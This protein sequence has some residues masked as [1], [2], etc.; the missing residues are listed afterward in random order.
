MAPAV[1]PCIPGIPELRRRQVPRR[2]ADSN[3]PVCKA[4]DFTSS[5]TPRA[6]QSRDAVCAG[7][8]SKALSSARKTSAASVHAKFHFNTAI[9][10]LYSQGHWSVQDPL[11]CTGALH[12]PVAANAYETGCGRA[13]YVAEPIQVGAVLPVQRVSLLES[14]AR[15]HADNHC[16]QSHSM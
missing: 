9:A 4:T 15:L 10:K 6:E 7:P 3:F 13:S 2:T 5:S 14:W 1:T 8:S 12:N 16:T 11:T